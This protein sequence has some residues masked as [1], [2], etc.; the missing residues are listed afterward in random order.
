LLPR[1]SF[2]G[3]P[4]PRPAPPRI[5]SDAP[6]ILADLGYI[7]ADVDRLISS[8]TSVRPNGFSETAIRDPMNAGQNLHQCS[9]EAVAV[10]ALVPKSHSGD[11][12]PNARRSYGTLNAVDVRDDGGLAERGSDGGPD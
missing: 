11:R 10:S 4:T 12:R 5:G 7:A 1:G 6:A 3:E 8:G 9:T 2:D